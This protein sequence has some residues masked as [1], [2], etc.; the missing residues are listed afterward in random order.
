MRDGNDKTLNEFL[1]NLISA[2]LNDLFKI[3][4]KSGVKFEEHLALINGKTNSEYSSI[5]QKFTNDI[6]NFYKTN[7]GIQE[8]DG[9]FKGNEKFD[10]VVKFIDSS[11]KNNMG[12]LEKCIDLLFRFYLSNYEKSDR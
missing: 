2:T 11:L 10:S 6:Y 5:S 12:L 1:K 3:F 7:Q 9:N 8:T 4:S